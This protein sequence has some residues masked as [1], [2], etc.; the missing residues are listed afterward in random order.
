MDRYTDKVTEWFAMRKRASPSRSI[1]K[2]GKAV[3]SRFSF[4]TKRLPLSQQIPFTFAFYGRNY[5]CRGQPPVAVPRFWVESFGLQPGHV[6]KPFAR[7][8]RPPQKGF[9]SAS[10]YLCPHSDVLFWAKGRSEDTRMLRPDFLNADNRQRHATIP[11]EIA[12]NNPPARDTRICIYFLN[13]KQKGITERPPAVPRAS[14][15]RP[16]PSDG[17]W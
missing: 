12:A 8:S 3:E 11:A 13:G 5:V 14:I 9:F 2:T 15:I 17:R 6:A 1:E 4:Q 16:R 10:N 7:Q